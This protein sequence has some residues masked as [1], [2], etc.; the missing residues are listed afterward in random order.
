MQ[1]NRKASFV[2]QKDFY[3]SIVMFVV[4]FIVKIEADKIRI[5]ESWFLPN[6]LFWI[7]FICA[8]VLLIQTIMGR[9]GDKDSGA[10]GFSKSEML[11][12]LCMILCWIV[13][14]WLGFYSAIFLLIVALMLIMEWRKSV[15]GWYCVSILVKSLIAAA[16]LYIS[17][18]ELFHI[19]T[20]V[21]LWI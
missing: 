14:P 1:E 9:T 4:A 20:P 6:V 12:N 8:G 16:I 3:V 2:K 15:S 11:G 18:A 5:R 7:M 19:V 13:M 21:G 17:F 10:M